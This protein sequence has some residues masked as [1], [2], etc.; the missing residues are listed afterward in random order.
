MVVS[1]AFDCSICKDE[2]LAIAFFQRAVTFYKMTRQEYVTQYT[3]V[4]QDMSFT[5]HANQ[6][7][8]VCLKI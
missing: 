4:I 8:C 6:I 1:Q 7:N 2:H 3:H 5:A